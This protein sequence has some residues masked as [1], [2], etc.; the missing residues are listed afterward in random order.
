[1]SEKTG[2]E[3]IAEERSRQIEKEGYTREHDLTNHSPADLVN[4]GIAYCYAAKG[5]MSA[6]KRIWPWDESL[7]KTDCTPG[8][9]LEKAGALIAAS[10]DM[11]MKFVPKSGEPFKVGENYMGFCV[12]FI[13]DE[14]FAREAIQ[15]IEDEGACSCCPITPGQEEVCRGVRCSMCIYSCLRANDG[16]VRLE[17]FKDLL[18]H[19]YG[20]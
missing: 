20:G 3:R 11:K 15:R 6:A 2:A 16:N 8:R 7:F 18:K 19:N 10:L 4:A 9:C 13:P 1:M 12:P 5:E 14:V 17:F